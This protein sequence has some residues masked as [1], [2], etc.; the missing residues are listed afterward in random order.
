MAERTYSVSITGDVRPYNSALD[1]AATRTNRF[2]RQAEQAGDQAGTGIS[3]GLLKAEGGFSRSA[4]AADLMSGRIREAGVTA[5]GFFAGAG[6]IQGARRIAEGIQSIVTGGSDLTETIQKAQVTFGDATA[7]VTS[8]A[9]QMAH[10]FGVAK[11]EFIDAAASIGLIG[12]AAGLS[13]PQA[14]DMATNLAKLAADATSFYNVPLPDVLDAIQSGLVGQVRPLRQYGVLLSDAAVQQEAVRLGLV[15]TGQQ[16]NDQQKVIARAS[17]IQKGFADASGDLERTQGSLA[18]RLRAIQGDVK[19]WAA[20][21]G[22]RAQPAILGLLD[23]SY[24]LGH[25][26]LQDLESIVQRLGPFF[27]GMARA[28]EGVVHFLQTAGSDVAPLVAGLAALGGTAVIGVLNALGSS[29]GSVAGFLGQNETLVRVLTAAYIA[30]LVPAIGRTVASFAGLVVDR[31]AG[32][33][34]TLAGGVDAAAAA[35]RGEAAAAG[36]AAVGTTEAGVSAQVATGRVGGMV[37]SL[38]L[39]R[40]AFAAVSVVGAVLALTQLAASLQKSR[41]AAKQ[42]VDQLKEGAD[43]K[44]P[45]GLRE[46]IT[47]TDQA[48]AAAKRHFDEIDHGGSLLNQARESLTE[49]GQALSGHANNWNTARDAVQ[50]FQAQGK[51]ARTMLATLEGNLGRVTSA[52]GLTNDGVFS[53]A[54]KLGIDLTK[55]GAS[56]V[57]T[58]I[59]AANAARAAGQIVSG[60]VLELSD[61]E[62]AAQSATEQIVGPDVAFDKA[63]QA[64]QAA[65]Q[66]RKDAEQQARDAQQRAKQQAK[67]AEDAAKQ[68]LQIAQA[69]LG[70]RQ[71]VLQVAE[72]ERTLQKAREDQARTGEVILKDER[73]LEA[74]RDAQTRAVYALLD[75][76]R[77]LEDARRR[78]AE[79]RDVIESQFAVARARS[80]H[81]QAI[82]EEFT[83]QQKLTAARDHGS[84]EEI[85]ASE[86]ELAEARRR[87][88][89]STFNSE[90]AQVALDRTRQDSASN[91]PVV[92]AELTLS[93]AQRSSA[94]SADQTR[95]AQRALDE[96]RLDQSSATAVQQAELGVQQSLLAVQQAHQSLT[97]AQKPA[98]ESMDVFKSKTDDSKLSLQDWQAQLKKSLDDYIQFNDNLAFLAQNGAPPAVIQKFQEMGQKGVDIVA[99]LRQQMGGQPSALGQVFDQMLASSL[100]TTDQFVLYMDK[101]RTG[102]SVANFW[103]ADL[104]N[105]VASKLGI[106]PEKAREIM[107]KYLGVLD[108]SFQAASKATGA[109]PPPSSLGMLLNNVAAGGGPSSGN[110]GGTLIPPNFGGGGGGTLAVNAIGG[111]YGRAAEQHVAQV[112]AP[113]TWRLWAEDPK[114]G[115]EAYV[116]EHGSPSRGLAILGEAASWYGASV[117]P[118]AI[119]RILVPEA[120]VTGG[121]TIGGQVN[122]AVHTMHDWGQSFVDRLVDAYNRRT[123]GGLGYAAGTGYQLLI[124]YLQSTGTPFTVSST[125]GGDHVAGSYHYRGLA[126]DFVGPSLRAIFDA[127]DPVGPSLAE[128]FYDPAGYSWK[129]GQRVDWTVGGHSD[130]VHAAVEAFVRSLGSVSVGT[131]GNARAIGQAM[132]AA[133]GWTGAEWDALDWLWGV[134]ESGWDPHATNPTSGAYGIPQALPAS[135]M[136]S[137]GPDWHDNAATQIRWGLDYIGGRYGDPLGAAAHE[138]QVNWYRHG[139]ILAQVLDQG[140]YLPQGW[141]L[142]G[143]FTGRP[144]PVGGALGG[145]LVIDVNMQVN[146]GSV[147]GVDDLEDRV[148]R[149]ATDAVNEGA[150]TLVRE[151]VVR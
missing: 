114:S 66:A 78:E 61:A 38:G 123:G 74:A 43:L 70:V 50:G 14:A 32:G 150:G 88:V 54:N 69:Q 27:G 132:A 98:G 40:S 63:Q 7:I 22:Q 125:T 107:E 45:Q 86:R 46:Y 28:G 130:H 59:A 18:N 9:D 67:A 21:M 20:E 117:V 115:R 49:V 53:L 148:K 87:V 142:A 55:A 122:A 6:L 135:K 73:D 128:L 12:K 85:V 71:A 92:E 23:A 60:A 34:F 119:G 31:I 2:A 120:T 30:S 42:Q 24:R 82:E 33:M 113:G 110:P 17:L 90:D 62:K 129:N 29:L 149:A 127:F 65:E 80:A 137:A 35:L 101:F 134:K 104:V 151:L 126:A 11:G 145:G 93:D 81:S 56:G 48:A 16:L 4:L 141:S 116:P 77:A 121:G 89:E 68:P 47:A 99:L 96:A 100:A 138:R 64:H 51:E 106:T 41:D 1:S 84:P 10:R 8:G 91:R 26:G 76:E 94:N 105:G 57:A 131:G 3:R 52:T 37:A 109:A 95:Q 133:R 124:D 118:N 44:T 58:L 83:A 108:S 39:L 144:E 79:Q 13:S 111:V 103:T 143:N 36:V 146:A 25:E 112:A 102:S 75:A 139:G 140:G 136:A 19:N 147:I 15:Q 72:A 5:I 97:D